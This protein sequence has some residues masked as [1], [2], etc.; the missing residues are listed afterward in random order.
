MTDRRLK[1][2]VPGLLPALVFYCAGVAAPAAAQ[3]R[4]SPA[5]KQQP[6]VEHACSVDLALT[7]M[8]KD[9]V[10]NALLLGLNRPEPEVA[11]FLAGAETRYADG[12]EL[13]RAAAAH[14]KLEQAAL[15]AEV[16][17]FKHVN[18]PPGPAGAAPGADAGERAAAVPEISAFARDVTLHVVLHE[19]GHAL[20]REFD[21]PILGNEET[22][23]DAFATCY[24]TAHLPERAADVLTA[25]VKS[26]M[27]EA[28]ETP[29]VDWSGEHDDDARRAFQIAALAVA[30]D[31][32]RYKNVAA[33]VGMSEAD[34]RNARDYGT[35]IH[36]SWRRVLAPFWMPEGAA[37][38]EAR[39]ICDPG[40]PLIARLCAGGLA[41]E[42][43]FALRRFDWH[44]Q[45]TVRFA[46][47]QGRAGWSRS[48]RTVTVHSQYVR[49]F[50]EQ[51]A[52]RPSS[53]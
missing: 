12:P 10:S 38:G 31:P 3:E 42:I 34:M 48:S 7:G 51:G 43:E 32:G 37:S 18:C 17:R 11:G 49:R 46:E 40:S 41:S 53:D 5:Q 36:R 30:A 15:A 4:Q 2:V 20:I 6:P 25:R 45:V 28:A 35:E 13:L 16:E 1:T 52:R 19:I 9:I 44:S 21:L 26:L 8:M 22:A 23:A 27:I 47:G 14:F 50:I 33:A 39:V 24:L 29:G